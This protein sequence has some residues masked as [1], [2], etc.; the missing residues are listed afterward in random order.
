VVDAALLL[1]GHSSHPSRFVIVTAGP[2]LVALAVDAVIGIRAIPSESLETLP[3]LFQR[4]DLDAV[5]AIGTLDCELLLVLQSARLVP[6][7]A[8]AT[9]DAGRAA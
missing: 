8:W 3:L 6:E 9:I 1:G 5:S 2:R 7:D 4:A